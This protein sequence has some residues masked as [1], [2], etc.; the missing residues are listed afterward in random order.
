[1]AGCSVCCWDVPQAR[2]CSIISNL[3]LPVGQVDSAAQDYA[4]TV[5]LDIPTP[6][7]PGVQATQKN[8]MPNCS[9]SIHLEG[10]AQAALQLANEGCLQASFA[11]TET[12]FRWDGDS[13]EADRGIC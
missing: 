7:S 5:P 6:R 8:Q 2:S 4:H 9:G 3:L 12:D 1:M 11:G 10:Q 13:Q